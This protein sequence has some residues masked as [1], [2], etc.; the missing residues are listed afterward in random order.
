MAAPGGPLLTDGS[1]I[2]PRYRK[3]SPKMW[4]DRSFRSLSF[5]RP[6][7]QTLW[8]YLLT[9]PHTTNLPGLWELGPGQ[10]AERLLWRPRALQRCWREIETLGMA[11]WDQVSRVLMVP[12]V[13]LKYD[14]PESPNVVKA[15]GK[16]YSEL[17]D[18]ELKARWV[19]MAR[20]RMQSLSGPFQGVFAQV[21]SKAMAEAMEE[22]RTRTRT[23]TRTD[24]EP[25]PEPGAGPGPSPDPSR[26]P[27][28][29][30]PTQGTGRRTSDLLESMEKRARGKKP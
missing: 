16:R 21:F 3:I 28:D 26:P 17:P 23:R 13:L 1:M 30:L 10:C 4:G 8:V 9:G 14:S 29:D 25:E 7:A 6:N 22:S 27:R 24:P 20:E 11:S 15:W 19:L 18:C 5:P 2:E 12:N